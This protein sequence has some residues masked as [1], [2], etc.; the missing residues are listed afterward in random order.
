MILRLK[1]KAQSLVFDPRHPTRHFFLISAAALVLGGS[2]PAQTPEPSG[3]H[4]PTAASSAAPKTTCAGTVTDAGGHPLAGATV[5]Y[6]RGEENPLQADL[7]ELRQQIT[8]QPDGTF[9]C[10]VVRAS[11]LLLARKPGLA[12]A[13]KQLGWPFHPPEE[14]EDEVKLVL[15]PPTP[16]TG[17]VVDEKG[18]PV[19]NAG[20]SV[21]MAV[22]EISLEGGTRTMNFLNGQPARDEFAAHTDATGRFRIDNFPTNATASL[23]FWTRRCGQWLPGLARTIGPGQFEI[24]ALPPGRKY[25]VVVSAPGYGQ[26]SVNDIDS[27]HATRQELA[28]VE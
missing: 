9:V 28:P 1:P 11:G 27:A 8:P 15:G 13:W 22:T 7:L 24:P 4:S 26:K 21:I 3:A 12:P 16:L 19:A 2:T 25:G 6:W 10:T 14:A 18:Q 23:I 20:V 17:T 5:E